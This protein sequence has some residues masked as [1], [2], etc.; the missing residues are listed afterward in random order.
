LE[1]AERLA[2]LIPNDAVL[3]KLVDDLRRSAVRP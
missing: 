1:Y 3:S 2:K